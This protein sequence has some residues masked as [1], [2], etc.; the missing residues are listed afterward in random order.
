LVDGKETD[1]AQANDQGAFA[2][3]LK[4]P[5]AN[6]THKIQAIAKMEFVQSQPNSP[7]TIV[8]DAGSPTIDAGNIVIR[9]RQVASGMTFD[10][11]VPV[12]TSTQ[13]V[14]ILYDQQQ[15]PLQDANQTSVFSG[16]FTAPKQSGS[17]QFGFSLVDRSGNATLFPKMATLT[18][19]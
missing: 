16:R 5:L 8:I 6:G 12:S 3:R 18:V 4:S 9:P 1:T 14:F 10:A 15:F 17:Y 11:F 19:Q 7:L 13:K 2:V